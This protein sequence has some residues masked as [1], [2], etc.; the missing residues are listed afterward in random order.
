MRHIGL[1][2]LFFISACGSSKKQ[3]SKAPEPTVTSYTTVDVVINLATNEYMRFTAQKKVYDTVMLTTT[4]TTNG[5]IIQE[6]K[7]VRDS[8]YA[9]WYPWIVTDS[10]G[11]VSLKNKAGGDSVIYR[12]TP[13]EKRLIL[14]DF[15]KNWPTKF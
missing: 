10:T 6:K 8:S 1:I 11:K 12:F 4:D 14:Q 9:V 2:I 3:K 13:I 15:D 5:K 7:L